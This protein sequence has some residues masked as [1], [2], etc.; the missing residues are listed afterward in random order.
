MLNHFIQTK[1]VSLAL[2]KEG[3]RHK[4]NELKELFSE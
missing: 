2:R 4:L 3:I 1:L